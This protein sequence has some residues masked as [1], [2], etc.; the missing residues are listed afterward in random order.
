[1][2]IKLLTILLLVFGF[3]QKEKNESQF[4][5][6]YYSP[7][8]EITLYLTKTRKFSL[9]HLRIFNDQGRLTK[10]SSGRFYFRKDTIH[11]QD[12]LH[13]YHFKLIE[14]D[15]GILLRVNGD[16]IPSGCQFYCWTKYYPDGQKKWNGGWTKNGKRQGGWRLYDQNG[17]EK[18]ITYDSG[19][20]TGT[21]DY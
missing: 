11:L 15:E 21:W 14:I 4:F 10:I 3:G 12:S 16:S 7:K 13:N 6:E 19:K 8:A 9:D 18:R 5:G 17:N 2:K 20:V 1:V